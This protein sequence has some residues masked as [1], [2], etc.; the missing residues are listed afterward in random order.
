MN[1]NMGIKASFNIPLI[2]YSCAGL[3]TNMM[4]L[5][6]VFCVYRRKNILIES[7]NSDCTI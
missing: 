4:C 5:A 3:V 7:V 6:L 1:L 2:S